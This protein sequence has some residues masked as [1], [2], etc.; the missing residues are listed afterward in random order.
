LIVILEPGT[1]E[2][3]PHAVIDSTCGNCED[4]EMQ[5]SCTAGLHIRGNYVLLRGPENLS[6]ILH[7][8]SGYGIFVERCSTAILEN[9]TITSGERDTNSR[10]TD[11]AIVVKHSRAVIRGNRIID[12]IGDSTLVASGVVGIM[13]ICGREGADL[14]LQNNRIIRNSWD[15]IA[16]YRDATAIIEGNL[17]DGVDK[18]RGSVVGGG[19]GV[20]IGVTWNARA[21]IRGNIVKRY[22]K[23]IGIFVDAHAVVE[24]NV[25]EDI[26]TWGIS[27][28]DAGKG[29]PVGFVRRNIIYNT[30]ACGASITRS[31]E[32][33]RPGEFV[34]NVIV[35]TGQNPMYDSPDYYCYQC[36]F[37]IHAV[38]AFFT[39][40]RNLFY[41]N[42]RATDD[43]PDYDFS[44]EDFFDR[45]ASLCH[46]LSEHEFLRNSDFARDFCA[47]NR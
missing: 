34:D 3:Q 15:G 29:A 36:A 4:P 14:L 16:L 7:T 5:I 30:G 46:S 37:A 11:A 24:T 42:R 39:I 26:I 22:W 17:V 25:V 32:A 28:W 38:P 12:N 45:S 43:L 10:A 41:D 6:A 33:G 21:E 9:L 18:A 31:R 8:R 13:G 23:G 35:H 2:L 44:R 1:Y 40:E 19:R 20:G 27:I 47:G